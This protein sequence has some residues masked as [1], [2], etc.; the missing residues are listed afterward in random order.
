MNNSDIKFQDRESWLTEAACLMLDEIIMPVVEAAYPEYDSPAFRIS[1]GFPKHSRG[2]RAI[3]VCFVKE[4]STDGVCEIFINPEIDNP[5]EVMEALAHELIHSVDNCASGHRNFFAAVARKIGLEGKFTATYAG[6]TLKA[7]LEEYAS[8]LG[9][10]PHSKMMIDKGHKKG[11]T[12]QVKVSCSDIDC[13][14]IFRTSQS[15]IAKLMLNNSDAPVC[16][17]CNSGVLVAS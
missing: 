8:L 2:G 12:R 14:F 9:G 3:A 15:Q 16:P 17:C 5:V 6:D 1:V 10:F 13:G 4:V 11:G 7:K